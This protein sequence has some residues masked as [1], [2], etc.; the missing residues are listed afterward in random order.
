MDSTKQKIIDSAIKLFVQKGFSGASISDI[1]KDAGINQSLIYHHVGNKNELWKTV[2]QSLIQNNFSVDEKKIKDF[3]SFLNYVLHERI[4][5]Y[6]SD[7]RILRLMQWQML[8][9]D[10]QNIKGGNIASPLNWVKH[11]NYLQKI[12]KIKKDY[13]A[14][15]ISAYIYSLLNG[16]LNTFSYFSTEKSKKKY[17]RMLEKT[18]TFLF[19]NK[20]T[21]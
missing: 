21:L 16:F 15:F 3:K 9:E 7:P 18:I 1:A 5:L 11:V 17:I 8:E 12:G 2:K 14:Q 4:A 19:C 6:E 13:S 10:G 20:N